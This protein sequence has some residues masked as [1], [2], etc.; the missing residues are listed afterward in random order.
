[1]MTRAGRIGLGLV[2]GALAV[3]AELA[4]LAWPRSRRRLVAFARWRLSV[5]GF[6]TPRHSRRPAAYLAA[7]IP[8]GLLGGV[9]I[10]L[11]GWGIA[12]TIGALW[13]WSHGR[14]ADGLAPRPWIIAYLVAAALVLGFAVVQAILGV[15]RLE[16]RLARRLLG[17]SQREAF[18]R[19]ISELA[20]SRAAT[21]TAVDEERRRIERD[22]HDGVQ[23]RMVAV[24][25]LLGR[26]RRATE[27]SAAG[28]LLRQAHTES[29]QALEDLREVAW[30]VYP[31]TLDSDGLRAA[32]ET[33]AERSVLPVDLALELPPLSRAVE[34]AVYFVVCEAVTNAIKHAGAGSITVRAALG[35]GRVVIEVRDDGAGGADPAGGG[36]TGLARRVA[37]LDGSF[38][39]DSPA[40]GPTVIVAEVPCA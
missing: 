1:M 17:P 15:V 33:V 11:V 6:S 22:L 5:A 18:E 2:L 14:D 31:A 36:L 20:E 8:V 19:R 28:E 38:Q 32:L 34:A 16:R 25:M 39:V 10:L 26:A 23:Q 4:G 3:P 9:L 30:R 37:A 29:Q 27:P 40:G 21:V 7:R 35:R 13:S 24:G 12:I